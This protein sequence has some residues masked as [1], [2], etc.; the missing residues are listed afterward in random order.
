MEEILDRRYSYFILKGFKP[1]N[2]V[3]KS[4]TVSLS[5]N[6]SICNQKINLCKMQLFII[7]LQAGDI[8]D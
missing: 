1:L 7:P 2:L 3:L 4:R 8:N 5:W 6:G